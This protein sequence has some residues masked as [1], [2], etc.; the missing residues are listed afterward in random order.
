MVLYQIVSGLDCDSQEFFC[1]DENLLGS[2]GKWTNQPQ[3]VDGFTSFGVQW[4]HR[5]SPKKGFPQQPGTHAP[6][7]HAPLRVTLGSIG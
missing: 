5:L 7:T 4:S 2:G 3:L 1:A 6:G